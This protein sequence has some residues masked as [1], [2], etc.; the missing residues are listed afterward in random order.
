MQQVDK[1]ESKEIQDLKEDHKGIKVNDIW[2]D[3]FPRG[4]TW[5]RSL[6]CYTWF[7][8][9]QR[10][11]STIH[12]RLWEGQGNCVFSEYAG[13]AWQG[14]RSGSNMYTTRACLMG[15]VWSYYLA[16]NK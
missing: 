13:M 12:E 9:K 16:M 1:E 5:Q 6:D 4:M 15:E 14:R 11:Y 10:D 8:L 3:D 2:K 7:C